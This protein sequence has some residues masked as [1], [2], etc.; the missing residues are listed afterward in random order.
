MSAVAWETVFAEQGI[1]RSSNLFWGTLLE[2]L[3]CLIV[4]MPCLGTRPTP[5]PAQ[6]AG[7]FSVFVF[8]KIFY[9]Y[10]KAPFICSR[11]STLS[12]S[13]IFGVMRFR[14]PFDFVSPGH[15]WI[16]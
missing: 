15:F 12:F 9:L 5:K 6:V 1:V 13:L 14:V 3:R 8:A 7:S 4:L 16:L 2:P 10:N 11:L